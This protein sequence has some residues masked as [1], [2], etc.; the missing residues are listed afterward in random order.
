MN[1]GKQF[2][3]D[4]K[5]SYKGTSYFY[6]RLRDSAKWTQGKNTSFTPSNPCDAI[7]FTQPYIW[8]LEL[9]ST[10]GTGVSFYPNTPWEKPKGTTSNVMIKANQVKELMEA[11][12]KP[13][14]IAGLIL[15]FRPR[16]L[17]SGTTSNKTYF[18]HIT[19]FVKFAIATG[20]ASINQNDCEQIGFKIT[21]EKKK[22]HYRYDIERFVFAGIN[23]CKSRGLIGGYN[24]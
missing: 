1:D 3:T 9:K 23:F 17:K 2:E 14:V 22:I 15:N 12:Q 8:L 10:K 11:V 16:E 20:K 18:I 13:G 6:M 19:D 4:W 21:G 24:G 7:Q 5:D